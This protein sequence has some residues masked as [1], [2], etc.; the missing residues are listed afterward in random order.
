MTECQCE[1]GVVN[2]LLVAGVSWL[3]VNESILVSKAEKKKKA[4]EPSLSRDWGRPRRRG[5][6]ERERRV[7]HRRA[8][9]EW[10]RS[11]KKEMHIR[12]LRKAEMHLSG[13]E[14][15]AKNL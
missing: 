15:I 9:E 6:I 7:F 14:I 12:R 1:T 10:I 3:R 4:S 2:G 13:S 11:W 5:Q 8:K